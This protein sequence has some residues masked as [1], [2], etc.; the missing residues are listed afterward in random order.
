M[1]NDLGLDTRAEPSEGGNVGKGSLLDTGG[2][3]CHQGRQ[4]VLSE[5]QSWMGG[6]DQRPADPLK[7]AATLGHFRAVSTQEMLY[8]QT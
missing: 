3:T 7:M 6:K 4:A 8:M 5:V 2:N 1:E